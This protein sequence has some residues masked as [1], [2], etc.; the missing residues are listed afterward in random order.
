MATRMNEDKAKQL[1]TRA[2]LAGEGRWKDLEES[3]QEM[4]NQGFESMDVSA[5]GELDD[6]K[7]IVHDLERRFI[8]LD[9]P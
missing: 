6:L 9:R 2:V 3:F 8:A 5:S 4:L 1:V 7:W